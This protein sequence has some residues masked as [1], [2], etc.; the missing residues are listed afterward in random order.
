MGIWQRGGKREEN[1]NMEERREERGILEYGTDKGRER[2]MR[3]WQRGGKIE[4]NGNVAERREE[5]G[6]SV[7][8]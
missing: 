2:N 4:E 1:G 3:I 8:G 7:Y 6:I 5:R